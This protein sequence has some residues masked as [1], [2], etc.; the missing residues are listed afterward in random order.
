[1]NAAGTDVVPA[2]DD[3]RLRSVGAEPCAVIGHRVR[4]LRDDA[5][6]RAAVIA[7][8]LDLPHL[9]LVQVAL[10]LLVVLVDDLGSDVHPCRVGL[11]HPLDHADRVLDLA[12]DH[13]HDRPVVRVGS[14]EHEDVRIPGRDDAEVRTRIT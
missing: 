12:L 5:S 1:M 10:E 2:D 7:T 8:L 9:Y 14:V 13:V 3:V 6:R 4:P 11:V